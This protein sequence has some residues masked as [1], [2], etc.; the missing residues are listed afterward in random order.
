MRL[1]LLQKHIVLLS[2]YFGQMQVMHKGLHNFDK[3]G[4]RLWEPWASYYS[5]TSLF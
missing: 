5:K 3:F 1:E 2:F 4:F